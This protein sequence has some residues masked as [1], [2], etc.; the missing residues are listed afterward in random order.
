MNENNSKGLEFE[1]SPEVAGGTYSN[2]AV[3]S[4]SNSEFIVDFAQNLPAMPKARVSCRV[5]MTPANAKR[6]LAAL[7]D[8]IAKYEAQ[9]GAIRMDNGQPSKTLNV[10]DLLNNGSKS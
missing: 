10:A 8:N 9:Y 6:L 1:I 2:L 3:I 4:H 5:I 7:N